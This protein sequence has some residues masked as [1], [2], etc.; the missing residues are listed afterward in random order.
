MVRGSGTSGSG[1]ESGYYFEV[2]TDGSNSYRIYK[3]VGNTE[4]VIRGPTALPGTLRGRRRR[5]A[6]RSRARRCARI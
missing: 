3:L 4:T 2:L 1:T 5:C 6:S